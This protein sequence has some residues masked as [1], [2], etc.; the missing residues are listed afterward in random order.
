MRLGLQI[1]VLDKCVDILADPMDK[2]L[3]LTCS[4]FQQV[5]HRS[6]S[7]VRSLRIRYDNMPGSDNKPVSTLC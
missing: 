7:D 5:N 1:W 3:G 4:A 2:W 6:Q